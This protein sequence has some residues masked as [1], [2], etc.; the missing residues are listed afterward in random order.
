MQ[1]LNLVALFGGQ[2]SEHVV[3]CM[4][5]K[6]IIANIDTEKYNVI[7]VGITEA[8]HWLKVDSLAQLEDD[9]WRESHVSAVLSPD[10]ED[11]CLLVMDGDKTEKSMWTWCSRFST[12]FTARTARCRAF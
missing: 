5:A 8:G 4:S 12:A 1:K 3:S 11:K 2:S 6:N 9:S 10:A 7:L